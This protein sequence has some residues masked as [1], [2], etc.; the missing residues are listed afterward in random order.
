MNI[1]DKNHVRDW[2]LDIERVLSFEDYE[3]QNIN[4]NVR[5]CKTL[6]QE[7]L[8]DSIIGDLK[9]INS[10][11]QRVPRVEGLDAAIDTI[12]TEFINQISNDSVGVG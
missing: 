3:K 5:E 12:N 6:W 9:L 10:N 7:F 8:E 4:F 2:M 11:L 1:I